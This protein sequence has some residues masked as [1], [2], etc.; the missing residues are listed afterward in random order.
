MK[1]ICASLI[2]GGVAVVAMAA[3]PGIASAKVADGKY[4]LCIETRY[5]SSVEQ[6]CAEYRVAGTDLIGPN[7]T[8]LKLVHTPTG[9]YADIPPVSRLTLLKTGSGYKAINSV[10]GVP[11]ATSSFLPVG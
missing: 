2:I 4:N 7:G 8:P 9:G 6:K 3:A 1:K 5:G 11:V 10:L